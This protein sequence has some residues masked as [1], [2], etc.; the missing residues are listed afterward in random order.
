MDHAFSLWFWRFNRADRF[1]FEFIGSF[2]STRRPFD[3]YFRKGFFSRKF[4]NQ[5]LICL[6]TPQDERVFEF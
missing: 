1:A 6:A 5:F 4:A 2:E 3:F